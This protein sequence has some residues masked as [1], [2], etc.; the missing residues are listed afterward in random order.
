IDGGMP[1]QTAVARDGTRSAPS[2]VETRPFFVTTRPWFKQG[3]GEPGP[4]WSPFY[5]FVRDGVTGVSCMS[6]YTAPGASAPSGV[7]H[8]DL[9]L[10]GIEAFLATLQIGKHGAVFLVDRDGHRVVTP[11]GENV[12]HAA[13]AI[14]AAAPQ[15][16]AATLDHPATIS[17][18]G[19]SYEVVFVPLPSVGDIGLTIGV[20][21]DLSDISR[22]AYRHAAIAGGVGLF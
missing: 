11:P 16:A 2:I 13:A 3:L 20:V 9:Q 4:I 8:A 17:A 7:F 14:D 15:R 1:K 18:G 10:Q 6:R 21:V 12:P 19:N 22:G 5:A